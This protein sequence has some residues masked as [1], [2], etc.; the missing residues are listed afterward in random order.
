MNKICSKC[1]SEKPIMEFNFRSTE[2]GK[3][4]SYCR[5]CG[6]QLTRSHYK[7]NKQ[8][9]LDKNLRSFRERRE[10]AGQIIPS[11]VNIRDK[12]TPILSKE[13]WQPLRLTGWLF[14]VKFLSRFSLSN[15]LAGVAL[16]L[17]QIS[18]RRVCC[19][20]YLRKLV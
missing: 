14:L 19:S 4:H 15:H 5:E 17:L 16:A 9:Y 18:R 20:F 1:K 12:K 10:Y 7:R 11:C 8:Q 3:R 2:A 13:G 6:K